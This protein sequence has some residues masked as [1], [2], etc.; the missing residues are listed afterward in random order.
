MI[1]KI[2]KAI[3]NPKKILIYLA[4]KGLINYDDKKYLTY[5]YKEHMG[6]ELNLE[7]PKTFNEKLQWL[8]LYNRNS[9]YTS[10]VDKYEVRKYVSDVIGK[11]YLI[12]C[13]GIY[14][15][16]KDI[17]FDKLPNQFVLKTTHDSGTVV[18]CENKDTFDKKN[19]IKLLKKR[20]KRKYFYLFREWPYKN[21]RPRIIVEQFMEDDKTHA[22]DDYKFYCFDGEPKVLMVITNRKSTPNINFF[23]MD[24]N[25]LDVQQ[26]YERGNKVIDKPK[27]FEDMKM[28]ARKLSKGIPHVRVDFYHIN[29]RIYFGELT[30][31]DS[32]G[33]GKFEPEEYDLIFGNYID[34]NKVDKIGYIK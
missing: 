27:G 19:A 12:P 16:I 14:D 24:F 32:A 3:K 7:N 5:I 30:F 34:L 31:F 25:E 22:L 1:K 29:N 4:S 10:L 6:K 9:K 28:L 11:Q 8:K 21:V 20:L 13:L 17:N 26:E 23:D 2:M 18:V 33:L 15:S